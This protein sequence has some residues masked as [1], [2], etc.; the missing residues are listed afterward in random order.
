MSA[1]LKLQSFGHERT[2][3]SGVLMWSERGFTLVELLIVIAI[4][5]ILAAIGSLQMMRAKAASNES[6]AIASMRAISS[7]QYAYASSCGGG[8]FAG[9]LPTLAAPGPGSTVPFLSPDLTSG[10]VIGKSGYTVTMT[11]GAASAPGNPDCNGTPTESAYY[12]SATPLSL[13]FHGS[14]SFAINAAGT[15][16]QV[17]AAVAPTEP[18]GLP[19]EPLR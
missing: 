1:A 17:A 11:P 7:A 6:A 16:W 12:A 13:G 4:I 8:S 2:R 14:R 18:F 15:I 10:V 5:A 19:A 9:L 3:G